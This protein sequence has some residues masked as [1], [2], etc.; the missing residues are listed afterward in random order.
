MPLDVTAMLQFLECGKGNR[1]RNRSTNITLRRSHLY[2]PDLP[3]RVDQASEYAAE[4]EI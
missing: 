2:Q 1:V 3:P 4:N